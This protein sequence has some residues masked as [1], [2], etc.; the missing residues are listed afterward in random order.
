MKK[1][2][3]GA[4]ILSASFA[5]QKA[6]VENSTLSSNDSAIV[7]VKAA[8]GKFLQWDQK[9]PGQWICDGPGGKCGE[10]KIVLANDVEM[11]R[12]FSKPGADLVSLFA[13]HDAM[14]ATYFGSQMVL[15]VIMEKISIEL[16]GDIDNTAFFVFSE[17]GNRIN[18]TPLK[19]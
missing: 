7:P 1:V 16:K 4:F 6:D 13:Q 17:G 19:K 2:I 11:L 5:C 10:D 3:L 15:D 14:L 9:D 12:A 18:V 8:F